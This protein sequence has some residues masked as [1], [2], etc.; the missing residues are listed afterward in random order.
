MNALNSDSRKV[1]TQPELKVKKDDSVHEHK[2]QVKKEIFI[3]KHRKSRDEAAEVIGMRTS[4][5]T[6]EDMDVI[7]VH[8][9]RLSRNSDDW[10]EPAEKLQFQSPS[11]LSQDGNRTRRIRRRTPSREREQEQC[12]SSIERRFSISP[13][14]RSS[15]TS[16]LHSARNNTSTSF[17]PAKVVYVP[18]T[19][20]SFVTDKS[21]NSD[22]GESAA[23]TTGTKR[24]TVRRNVG[25]ASPHSQSPAKANGNATEHDLEPT[26]LLASVRLGSTDMH[27][28]FAHGLQVIGPTGLCSCRMFF[29]PI[30]V[31]CSK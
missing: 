2:G 6:K 11:S 12:S 7:P 31:C 8:C 16:T 27:C 24:I 21:N 29:R 17:K 30:R 28:S 4:S 13:V 14:R 10:R 18:A 9:G 1:E 15:D 26:S 20:T 22:C 5:C 23:A 3:I 19:V 25:A